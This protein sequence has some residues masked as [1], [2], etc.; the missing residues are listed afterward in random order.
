MKTIIII[1]YRNRKIHL[2]YFLK[3]SAPL[4]K[5]HIPDLEIIIVEQNWD[6][7]LFNRGKLLNIGFHYYNDLE[8]NYILHDVDI[9]PISLA[10]IKKYKKN[11]K[12]NV[13]QGIYNYVTTL[14]GIIKLN[15]Y[16]FKKI[17]GFPNNYWG[18]GKEDDCLQNRSEFLNINIK[19]FIFV[20]TKNKKKHFKFFNDINDRL[21]YKFNEK[22]LASKIIKYANNIQKSKYITYSGINTLKYTI[23]KENNINEYVKHIVVKL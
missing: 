23:E 20:Q 9:N 19:K 8:Y 6:I 16:T 18:W 22:K 1:P 2:D 11:V 13:I 7:N 4:L 3:H 10:V 5:K 21:R 15:G 17:N 12:N 14:G